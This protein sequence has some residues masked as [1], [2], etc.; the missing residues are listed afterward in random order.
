MIFDCVQPSQCAIHVS[1]NSLMWTIN[2][3]SSHLQTC[4]LFVY[5]FTAYNTHCIANTSMI[6]DC[7]QPSQ[8]TIHASLNSLLRPINIFY[9][10]LNTFLLF[11]YPFPPYKS[12]CIPVSFH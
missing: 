7:V 9:S 1:L 2:F 3:F 12:H 11:P 10:Y 4:W 5:T 8:C 6:F